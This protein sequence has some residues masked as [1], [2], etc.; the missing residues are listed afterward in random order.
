MLN[1][2]PFFKTS[3]CTRWWKVFVGT[4]VQKKKIFLYH[5]K[6]IYVKLQT[7][8]KPRNSLLPNLIINQRT[9][10]VRAFWGTSALTQ[11]KDKDIDINTD[12]WFSHGNIRKIKTLIRLWTC[13]SCWC[14]LLTCWILFQ[15]LA[16]VLICIFCHLASNN[17]FR[18]HHIYGGWKTTYEW[19]KEAHT[20]IET[21][22]NWQICSFT[23]H[24]TAGIVLNFPGWKHVKVQKNMQQENERKKERQWKRARM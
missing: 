12:M 5:L 20:L 18:I 19:I 9:V 16:A 4:P 2:V 1:V 21:S 11:G 6:M 3:C 24:E 8:F 13:S 23:Q 10:A 7:G 14:W 15:L 22:N 17:L